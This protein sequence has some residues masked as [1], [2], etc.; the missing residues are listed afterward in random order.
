MSAPQRERF[1]PMP[2]AMTRSADVLRA[3]PALERARRERPHM[4][5]GA[6]L[7]LGALHRSDIGEQRSVAETIAD[8]LLYM[9]AIARRRRRA[10]DRLDPRVAAGP[11]EGA[12][13][14]EAAVVEVNRFWKAGDRPFDADAALGEPA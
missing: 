14:E 6:G 1:A 12:P 7:A 2:R 9:R 5:P 3:D 4:R 8:R 10:P 11:H 13:S